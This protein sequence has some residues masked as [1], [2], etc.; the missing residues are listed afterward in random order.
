MNLNLLKNIFNK[1]YVN[2]IIDNIIDIKFIF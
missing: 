2:I 1:W